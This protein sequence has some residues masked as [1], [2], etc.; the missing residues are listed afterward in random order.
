VQ[1]FNKLKKRGNTANLDEEENSLNQPADSND[2][3][4]GQSTNPSNATSGAE[5]GIDQNQIVQPAQSVP[6]PDETKPAGGGISFDYDPK[7]PD[8]ITATSDEGLETRDKGSE[9]SEGGTGSEGLRPG[10]ETE[11]STEPAK[12]KPWWRFW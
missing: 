8:E 2:A 10:M 9:I 5:I 3:A 4:S 1:I 6:S 12:K 7:N 11:K